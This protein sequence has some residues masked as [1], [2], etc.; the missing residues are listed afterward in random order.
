MKA[1]EEKLQKIIEGTIQYVVPLFQ[2]A[3]SWTKSEW[4]ALWDDIITLCEQENPRVHFMG[5]IVTMPAESAPGG[6][7][8]YILIDGQQRITTIFILLAALRDKA[9]PV[10]QKLA[11]QIQNTI[12]VNQYEEGLDFYKIQPTQVDR[13]AFQ[14]IIQSETQSEENGISE[15]YG[16]FEKKLRLSKIDFQ[17]LKKVICSNFSL[18][19]VVLSIDDDPYLVFESLN[20][21]GKSLTQA[22]LIR[23][24]FFMKIEGK[25][26]ESIYYKYWLPIQEILGENLTEFI[27]HYL[28]KSGAEVKKGEIYFH[29]KERISE[30]DPVSY[31]K[32]L[33][34][35]V[36]Y[37]T[38]LLNPN[39]EEKK[40]V[41]KYL[42]RLKSLEAGTIY[43]FLLN[44]YDDWAKSKITEHQFI[45][46][47]KIIENFLLRRFVCN[48]QTRGLNRL[49][50]LLY[51]QVSNDSNLA[52]CNFI[53][54]LKLA[55]QKQN[56][57]KDS[58]F[59]A[60]LMD[61]QLYGPNR[62]QKAKLILESIEKSLYYK[63]E[64]ILEGLTIEHIM[65]QTLTDWWKEHLGENWQI[66][67]D[68]LLHTLGNLTL[69]GSNSEL[70]NADFL[71]KRTHFQDSNLKLNKYFEDKQAW[72]QEHIEA[73]AEYLA[74]IA[75][76]IW[77]Y[78]GEELPEPYVPKITNCKPKKLR[79]FSQ[80]NVVKNWRD[81]L[82]LT[83]NTIADFDPDRFQDIVEQFPGFVAW[84]EKGFK[85]WSKLN[86]GAFIEVYLSA[87]RI[88]SFCIKAIQTAEIS[89]E[90]W[91]LELEEEK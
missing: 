64:V 91:Q 73:R 42:L 38:K 30:G 40:E 28:T 54:G 39:R 56:Y 14:Q 29:I 84:D 86:N 44:C 13:Q 3:Y 20:A 8:K 58:Q 75:L 81:V 60:R 82:K 45:E 46:I 74:D 69:T 35:F 19:S 27:R 78:F 5:S 53:D 62:S 88:H 79:I 26:Q 10:D 21:K 32:D 63:Q 65:P 67:H 83:L 80:E 49:F 77:S 17:K 7:P 85:K 55:L 48:I 68:L 66:T 23:N 57:P 50:A 12:L 18:V 76:K 47:L 87:K 6:C 41:R 2:R 90:D 37:Y 15:C 34:I 1:S 25:N 24:Y 89:E 71:E 59:K 16:F 31:I 9:K 52:G 22:D 61:V 70:S 43:P 11:D 72:H 33:S 4:E 36:E 51:S